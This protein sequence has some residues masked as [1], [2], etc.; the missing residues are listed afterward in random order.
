M[1]YEQLIEAMTPEMHRS[2]KRAVE[3]GKW[4]NGER[5]SEEQRSICLRAV[6]T[7]DQRLPQAERTGYI[8]RTRPDGTQHGQDP[9]APQTLKILDRG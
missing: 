9:L 1:T 2:L 5:L 8:D 3:L 7:Y 4:P 6:I